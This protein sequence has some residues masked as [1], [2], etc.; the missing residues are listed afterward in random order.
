MAKFLYVGT[1]A[2]SLSLVGVA[3]VQYDLGRM[4]GASYA[5][6]ITFVVLTLVATFSAVTWWAL[7]RFPRIEL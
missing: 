5:G 7:H 3:H 2:M 4:D 1:C 6:L